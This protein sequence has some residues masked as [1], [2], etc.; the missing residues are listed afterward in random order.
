MDQINNN[1]NRILLLLF[2]YAYLSAAENM[3]IDNTLL[4][5]PNQR[6]PFDF[7]DDYDEV[8]LIFL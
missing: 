8:I 4:T 1:Y 6:D 5:T 7:T 3:Q 2:L